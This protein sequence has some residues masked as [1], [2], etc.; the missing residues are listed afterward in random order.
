[1]LSRCQGRKSSVEKSDDDE[2]V[3]NIVNNYCRLLKYTQKNRWVLH[4][5]ASENRPRRRHHPAAENKM[6]KWI[7]KRHFE[8]STH[9]QIDSFLFGALDAL[10]F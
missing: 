1:M 3:K 7:Y 5:M 10:G 6:G 4:A 9:P 2:R 8:L